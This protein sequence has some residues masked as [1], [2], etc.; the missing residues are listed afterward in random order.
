[1]LAALFLH[2]LELCP[3]ADLSVETY[4]FF[5]SQT[6]GVKNFDLKVLSLSYSWM[7]CFKIRMF[8]LGFPGPSRGCYAG[9]GSETNE[10]VGGNCFGVAVSL[11]CAGW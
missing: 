2:D 8:F 7:L 10:E 11:P 6:L 1:M 9:S 4:S 3:K 5:P